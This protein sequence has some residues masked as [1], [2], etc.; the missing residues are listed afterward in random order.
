MCVLYGDLSLAESGVAVDPEDRALGISLQRQSPLVEGLGQGGDERLHRPLQ[1]GLVF[2][3]A[4]LE[5]GPVVVLRSS[6]RKS[7]ASGR[8]PVKRGHR[9]PSVRPPRCVAPSYAGAHR[10]VIPRLSRLSCALMSHGPPSSDRAERTAVASHRRLVS[11]ARDLAFRRTPDPY[12]VLVSEAMAQQ[13]QAERAA[14][15]WERFMAPFPTVDALAAASPADVLRELAGSRLRPAGAGAWR[16]AASSSLSTAVGCPTTSRRLRGPAWCR[17]VHRAGGRRDRLRAPGRRGRRQRPPGPRPDPRRST[18]LSRRTRPVGPSRRRRDDRPGDVDPC[19]HGPRGDRLSPAPAAC[20][21][22]P[23]RAWCRTPQGVPGRTDA[24]ADGRP[25]GAP[26]PGR[27]VGSAAGSSIACGARAAVP[28][29]RSTSR[30]VIIRSIVSTRPRALARE[31]IVETSSVTAH[32]PSS[33]ARL[34]PE[35]PYVGRLP[36]TGHV[37]Q[38]GAGADRDRAA[39][40]R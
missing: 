21:A 10:P 20:D 36:L 6:A 17:P 39:A 15:Y 19:R 16:A 40:C 35:A 18:A 2:R 12:A 38:P 32:G 3:L 25:S 24:K 26:V 29:S 14:A 28:G 22:C 37:D 27:T 11:R 33:R 23:V 1:E 8:K 9:R 31:G 30:S 4:R 34:P 5:P 13:T 7:V